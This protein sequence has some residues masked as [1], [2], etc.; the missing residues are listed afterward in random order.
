[1][2]EKHETRIRIFRPVEFGN[3]DINA[4]RTC[5]FTAKVVNSELFDLCTEHVAEKMFHVTNAPEE[6]L[7]SELDQIL[8]NVHH[9]LK[10][11]ETYHSLSVG[12]RV[13]V[14]HKGENPKVWTCMSSGWRR[15]L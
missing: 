15:D 12:D 10:S 2:N 4:T 9:N 11:N 1:M 8:F 13:E 6:L 5:V 7:T 14:M 3:T